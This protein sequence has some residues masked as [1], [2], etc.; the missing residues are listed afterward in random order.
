MSTILTDTD[1]AK[2]GDLIKIGIPA[3]ELHHYTSQL[4]TVLDSIAVINKLDTSKIVPTSQTHGLK[5]V[6]RDDEPQPG[7]DITKYPN[8]K[9]LRGRY[10]IVKKVL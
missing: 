8:K 1:T 4:N 10:F 2:I 3:T 6:L 7:L 9:N 5:N